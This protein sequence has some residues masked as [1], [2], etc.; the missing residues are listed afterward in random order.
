MY[1]EPHRK[2]DVLRR[3][4]FRLQTAKAAQSPAERCLWPKQKMVWH[5]RLTRGPPRAGPA[6]I[7]DACVEHAALQVAHAH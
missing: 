1:W 2:A 6:E 7:R 4:L 5:E 3:K